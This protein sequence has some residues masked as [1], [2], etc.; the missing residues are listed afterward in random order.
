MTSPLFPP[1]RG[2]QCSPG[3]KGVQGTRSVKVH[4]PSRTII[5]PPGPM[6][7]G[8]VQI[9]GGPRIRRRP[10]LRAR[11]QAVCTLVGSLRPRTTA[12]FFQQLFLRR[13]RPR[14]PKTQ[15]NAPLLMIL[16]ELLTNLFDPRDSPILSSLLSVPSLLL[17][18]PQSASLLVFGNQRKLSRTTVALSTFRKS[19]RRIATLV[20]PQQLNRLRTNGFISLNHSLRSIQCISPTLHERARTR[21][22]SER[23]PRGYHRC[24]VAVDSRLSR[25]ALLH[26]W[27]S[28]TSSQEPSSHRAGLEHPWA[29]R[30]WC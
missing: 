13:C 7:D 11:V 24:F 27:A 20:H 2:A 25:R 19:R 26:S 23:R 22:P 6:N 5:S 30:L 4:P 17:Q 8:T 16:R 1:G 12:F 3:D 14:F 9:E 28:Y 21:L 10:C 18:R 29:S 15:R